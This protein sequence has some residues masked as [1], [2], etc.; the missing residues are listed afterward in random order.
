[1]QFRH[2]LCNLGHVKILGE[3]VAAKTSKARTY[4][5][6]WSS[7]QRVW[8]KTNVSGSTPASAII[9][10][11]YTSIKKKK[12]K[13]IIQKIL[14]NFKFLKA[15]SGPDINFLIPLSIGLL[16]TVW[17]LPLSVLTERKH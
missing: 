9:Y 16:S 1:M 10:D 17:V 8:L 14:E 5:R 3:L 4:V 15:V 12:K 7:G 6:R 11:A 2:K 13:K